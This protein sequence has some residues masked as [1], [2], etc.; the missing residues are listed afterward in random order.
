LQ[1]ERIE[2]ILTPQRKCQ[3]PQKRGQTT[4]IRVICFTSLDARW[5]NFPSFRRNQSN[6]ITEKRKNQEYGWNRAN[7]V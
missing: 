5:E 6:F 2:I 7:W 3:P 1:E 4:R